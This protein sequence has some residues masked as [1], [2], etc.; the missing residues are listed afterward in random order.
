TY[1]VEALDPRRHLPRIL[2]RLVRARVFLIGS[3]TPFFDSAYQLGRL[4]FL[5]QFARR[6]CVLA[7]SSQ[8]IASPWGRRFA[9]GILERAEVVSAREPVSQRLLEELSGGQAVKF[10]PDPVLAYPQAAPV[11]AA[12]RPGKPRFVFCPRFVDAH[13]AVALYHPE[14]DE[15]EVDAFYAEM[16]RFV[17]E[18]PRLGDVTLLP[19]H[20]E[21]PDDDRRFFARVLPR[22]PSNGLAVIERQ[23]SVSEAAA[24]IDGATVVIGMRLHAL[25]LAAAFGKPFLPIS[26][27]PK[28]AGF[29]DLYGHEP[30]NVVGFKAARALDALQS[31][32]N[33]LETQAAR[34]IAQTHA[35][36]AQFE[37]FMDRVLEE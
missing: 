13:E 28:T 1:G 22:G 34:V 36:R 30:L 20:A 7:V 10:V 3:G 21:P 32:L 15:A 12:S 2:E 31:V 35:Y 8:V 16:G 5:A 37:T 33:N 11:R 9:R 25:V 19:L 27:A 18:L 23:P 17:A 24:L 26:Y 14:L 4:R 29:A 6:V